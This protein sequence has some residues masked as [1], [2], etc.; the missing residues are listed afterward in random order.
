VVALKVEL[1]G[2]MAPALEDRYLPVT[3]A[4]YAV[5]AWLNSGVLNGFYKPKFLT[6]AVGMP[7]VG[8]VY[9]IPKDYGNSDNVM[10]ESTY[11]F[12]ENPDTDVIRGSVFGDVHDR[13][14]WAST[15][16]P[17]SYNTKSRIISGNPAWL[18]GI[19][20]P[21][22]APT[23]T[24]TL[25]SSSTLVSTAYVVTY[26]TEYGEES[27]PSPPVSGTGKLDATWTL[28]NI[29]IPP[30]GDMG[31]NRN[32]TKKRLYR[33][34]TGSTGVA[35]FFQITELLVNVT[36]YVDTS[37]NSVDITGNHILE[38]EFWTPPPS[39]LEG[40]CMGPNGVIAGWRESEVWFS[41]PF[42]PHAW[43]SLAVLTLEYPI[44]GL[45][46]IGQTIFAMTRGYPVVIMGAN[47]LAMMPTRVSMF[48]P[49]T[50]RGSIVTFQEG[51]YYSSGNGLILLQSGVA[52]NISQAFIS[53]ETWQQ[54]VKS[55]R[56]RAGKLGT[57]TY[58]GFGTVQSG[59]FQNDTF[60]SNSFQ[61]DDFLGVGQGVYIEPRNQRI[62]LVLL[63][64]D[65]PV[66]NVQHDAWSSELLILKGNKVYWLDLADATQTTEPCVWH[67]KD[68]QAQYKDN[69]AAA[70]IYFDLVPNTPTQNP[71]RN[72][73]QLQS[74]LSEDQYA[75]IRWYGDER[76][77]AV[78]E[79]RTSGELLR[80]PSDTKYD[81]FKFE[82]Q[83][84]VDI[85]SVH[86]GSSPKDLRTV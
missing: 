55:G 10:G 82:I 60:Q 75:L 81:F 50:S 56:F 13:Y 22:T 76:L 43:S 83:T 11:M 39:D 68:F 52:S 12:F 65:E 35:T 51:V 38:S 8:K 1:F 77:L 74:D 23:L 9:R 63:E 7:M 69:F 20:L 33:A 37:I 31:V 49:C 34:I 15:S 16:G 46:C 18:L 79:V 85:T 40:F 72:T 47:P 4:S 66:N 24:I 78:H 48:E 3:Q 61:Q 71:I 59:V 27:A 36:S 17:P 62:S 6:E 30:S 53:K 67:S 28:T 41:E 70:K 80:L 21:A 64:S 42:R 58:Y 32:I 14:Y 29:P 5:N 54:Y 45:A 84:R 25:G 44:V 86:F 2:G 73:S 57:S 19:P 26:V